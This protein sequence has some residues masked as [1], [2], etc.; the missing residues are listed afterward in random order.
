MKRFQLFLTML[1]IGNFTLTA[2]TFE[3]GGAFGGVGD[4]VVRAMAVDDDGN[5]YTT[6]YFTDTSDLDPTEDQ[7]LLVSNGFYDIFLQKVDSDGNFVGAFGFGGDFFDYGTGVEVD[8]DGII[9]VTGV[10]QETVDFDPSGNSFELTSAGSEDIFALKLSPQG[11]LIWAKSMGSPAYE[12]PVSI[13]TDAA[14]NVYISGY[15]SETGDY[16]PGEGVFELTSNGGQDAF[17][18][19]LDQNGQFVWALNFGGAEQELVLGMDVNSDGD[20]F[21]TGSFASTVDFDPGEEVEERNPINGRDGYALKLDTDGNFGYATVFGGNGN[22][23]AWDVALDPEGNAYAAGGFNG[24]FST[25]LP[26]P[27]NSSNEDAFVVKI[28]PLGDLEWASV[29]QGTDFQ[30]AYD[31]NTDPNGNVILAGYFGGEA[32]FDPSD[33]EF[34]LAK[35][36]TEPYD[37]FVSMLSTEG[38]LVYAANFGGSNFL[39]HHGVDTDPEGNIYLSAAFQNT[40]DIDPSPDAEENVS[41]VA[42]RDNYLIKLSAASTVGVQDQK[43]P[44]MAIFPNPAHD[45]ITVEGMIGT[46]YIIVDARG[47][48]IDQGTLS[49]KVIDISHLDAG[50]YVFK[51][52]GYKSAKIVKR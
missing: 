3:W 12:E 16:D 9:Y 39:D 5:V 51:S 1:L 26:E 24:S 30:N 34:L 8:G 46:A 22:V 44:E 42:F 10:F 6:G 38:E 20:S 11:Q 36:S 48:T 14:G 32:D 4:D 25:G 2:Q 43:L 50:L 40:V 27:L 47:K 33:N 18:V 49:R 52:D 35:E 21:I 15:F 28:D 45:W 37:A 19:K 7:N 17:V 13:G 41:V 29:I 23:T 31:V